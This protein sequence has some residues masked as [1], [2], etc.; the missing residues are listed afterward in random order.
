MLEEF[1][2]YL[3][4]QIK[5]EEEKLE[6][7]LNFNNELTAKKNNA[8]LYQLKFIKASYES[9]SV[10]SFKSML[11]KMDDILDEEI[12]S[13]LDITNNISKDEYYICSTIK[14]AVLGQII[15]EFNKINVD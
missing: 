10:D 8:S 3:N 7:S 2:L 9:M 1:E 11:G 5:E 12:D 13:Y 6:N 4:K 15:T 14:K